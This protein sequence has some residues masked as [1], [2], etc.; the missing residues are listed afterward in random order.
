MTP[1]I[2]VVMASYN[3]EQYI[4]ESIESVLNQSFTD[5]E[6]NIVD[7]K[8]Q[9]SSRE[10]IKKYAGLDPRIRFMF[11]EKNK[12]IA[13]TYNDGLDMSIG[14]Y[15]A[16]ASSD[17][18]WKINKLKKQLEVLS[19]DK[20]L[21]V[22]SDATIIDSKGKPTGG[23]FTELVKAK[24]RKKSGDIFGE[25]V[26][27]NYLSGHILMKREKNPA[28][29]FDE[30]LKYLNDYKFLLELAN[31]YQYQFLPEPL[32]MYRIH[33]GNTINS[34][35]VNWRRDMIKFGDEVIQKYSH[36]IS[37]RSKTKVF[38]GIA[39]A[40]SKLGNASKSREN[41][42]KAMKL[43]PFDWSYFTF[44]VRY[45]RKILFPSEKG[46]NN[47]IKKRKSFSTKS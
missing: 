23:L 45:L 13:R 44:L 22:W 40:Y 25:L 4:S 46:R 43:N 35:A 17:D 29:R 27:G 15:I 39:S 38:L 33:A 2:S 3:H 18:K 32:V 6:L 30:N 12:G 19:R 9:D 21:I 1:L 41:L 31:K 16:L 34:D 47:P 10:I 8:S 11:H 42:F 28:L 24:R 5:I 37:N 14:Q 7:D 26:R 36:K 20:S